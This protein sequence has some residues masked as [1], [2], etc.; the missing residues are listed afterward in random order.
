MG[1]LLRRLAATMVLAVMAWPVHAAEHI[2]RI[3]SDYEALSFRFEL[4]SLVIAP[5]DTVIWVNDVEE[6]HNVITYPGGIP[7]GAKGFSSPMLTQAGQRFSKKFSIEGTYQ[8]HCM[9]HLPMAMTG[10]IV[11]GQPTVAGGFHE[12]NEGEINAYR[13]EFL[14]WFDE[15]H[16]QLKIRAEAPPGGHKHAEKTDVDHSAHVGKSGSGSD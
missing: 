8:Y 9:P 6:D 13:S 7:K 2:V 14:K 5:G 12:P 11:V 3:I 1:I 15:D 10:E 4:A 16:E